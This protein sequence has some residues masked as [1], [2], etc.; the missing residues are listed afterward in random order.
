LLLALASTVILGSESAGTEGHILLSDG[1]ESL[2]T[3]APIYDVIS[4]ICLHVLVSMDT[5]PKTS[6]NTSIRPRTLPSK[7][8]PTDHSSV[9]LPFDAV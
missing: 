4:G 3:L 1:S 8:F 2:Q 7:S 9:I 5:L 6:D